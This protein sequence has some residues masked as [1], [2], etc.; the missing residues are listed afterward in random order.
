MN[1]QQVH[2]ELFIR[3]TPGGG[4]TLDMATENRAAAISNAEELM[5]AGKV[6]AVR[7]LSLADGREVAMERRET[8]TRGRQLTIIEQ[9]LGNVGRGQLPRT[10]ENTQGQ[11]RPD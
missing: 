3:R 1:G 2:Y 10:E 9:L 8:P 4:W 11:R 6:A 5:S 7:T